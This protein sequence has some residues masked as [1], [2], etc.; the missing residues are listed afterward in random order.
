MPLAYNEAVGTW[1]PTPSITKVFWQH[2]S[3]L[4]TGN[5]W[6]FLATQQQTPLNS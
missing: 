3:Q 1:H 2:N 6:I 5:P 4:G